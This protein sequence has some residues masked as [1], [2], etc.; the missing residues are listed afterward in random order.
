[1]K[2]ILTIAKN[3]F[4]ETVRDKILLSVVAVV[5]AIIFFSLFVATISL[6]QSTRIILDF[7]ITAIYAL[8]IFIAIFIGS[9]LMY[10]EIE[11]KTFYLLLPKP[12]K[13]TEIILGKCLGLTITTITVTVLATL[14]L[15][16]VVLLNGGTIFITSIILSL[17]LSTLEA[18]V[19]I[20]ISILFSSFTS[21]IVAAVATLTFYL[22][23]HSG[24]IFRYIILTT[25]STTL[26]LS[27]MAAY[28]IFPNLE[29]FNI[30]NDVVYHVHTNIYSILLS[31]LYAIAYSIF[32]LIIAQTIF[33]KR[34]F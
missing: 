31:I 11:R 18:I 17:F 25:K 19:L 13:R 5:L 6:D 27:A 16:L 22:V 8:Q 26:E 10:K 29:K 28:Y 30:R 21:P 34:D 1:M 3:T 2:R 24:E 23:G 12:V 33:K 20:L 14:A 7:G 4:R 32:I 15:C 9:M